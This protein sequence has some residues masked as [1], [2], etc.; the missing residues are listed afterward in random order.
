[1]ATGSLK[2]ADLEKEKLDHLDKL[3]SQ[4]HVE[5]RMFS[6][7][8]EETSLN[9][10]RVQTQSFLTRELKNELSSGNKIPR[11]S[12]FLH[13]FTYFVISTD[14]TSEMQES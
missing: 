7:L 13:L 12:H 10:Y 3:E 4:A 9:G 8:V 6:L 11:S 2:D 14:P 5:V 1:M